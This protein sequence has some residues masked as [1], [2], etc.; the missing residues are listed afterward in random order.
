MME[1]LLVDSLTESLL[2]RSNNMGNS[3]KSD[4]VAELLYLN[5]LALT[6]MIQDRAQY[7][8]AKQYAK[9]TTSYGNYLLFRNSA[10][11]L[12]TLAHQVR[13]PHTKKLKLADNQKGEEYL[14]NLNFSDRAHFDMIQRIARGNNDIIMVIAPY[15]MRLERQLNIPSKIRSVRREIIDWKDSSQNSR[16]RTVAKLA[17]E[18]RRKGKTGDLLRPIQSMSRY[19]QFDQPEKSGVLKKAAIAGAGAVAGAALGKKI[20][21]KLDKDPDKY[22]KAGAGIGALAGYWAGKR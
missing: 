21:T 17:D 14:D 15:L 3:L 7:N 1:L 12:Y 19:K 13:Y 2:Y 18:M 8:T 5:T 4:T 6:L 20:A 22:S 16:E 11:D 10:T 9:K